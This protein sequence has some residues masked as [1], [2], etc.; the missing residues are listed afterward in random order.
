MNATNAIL[1][2]TGK[3]IRLTFLNY[4]DASK[5][6]DG[7]GPSRQFGDIRYNIMRWVSDF[8]TQDLF[9]GATPIGWDPRTG[10]VIHGS[11]TFNDGAVRDYYVQRIDAFLQTVGASA[12]LGN[13]AP[14][15][16]GGWQ[17]GPC[18]NGATAQIVNQAVVDDHNAADSLY[19]KMQQYLNLH[20]PNP[21]DDHIGPQDMTAASTEDA[22]FYNAYFTLVPYEIFQDPDANLFVTREGGQ[23]VYGTPGSTWNAL[24]AEAQFQAVSAQISNGIDPTGGPAASTGATDPVA[25]ASFAEKMKDLTTA[26]QN[27]LKIAA[28]NGGLR[29]DAPGAFSVETVMEQDAQQCVNGQW[30]TQDQWVQSHHRR[31]LA[32]GV[33]ARVRPQHGHV[34]PVHG[35][36]RPAQLHAP[37]RRQRQADQGRQ[38]QPA[39]PGVL[40]LGDGV[41]RLA[42]APGL[43]AGLGRVRPGLHRLDVLQR[44]EAGRQPHEGRRRDGE[45]H[46]LRRGGRRHPGRRVPLQGPARLLHGREHRLSCAAP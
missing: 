4:N 29:L 11:I 6:G 1:E 23:G 37:D 32:A 16:K 2:K 7:A 9:A 13:N 19:Q 39:V 21:N 38:R 3:P 12:G 14:A 43:E 25:W 5:L 26:H 27:F 28:I 20:G 8:D 15:S 10:E 30:Q 46:A 24:K 22:D 44:R 33:L 40:V 17:T 41:Q 18:S 34:A 42:G 35:Q 31:L 36:H 45:L